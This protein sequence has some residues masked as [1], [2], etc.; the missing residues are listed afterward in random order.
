MTNECKEKIHFNSKPDKEKPN[1]N[2][3]PDKEKPNF[4]NK[5][6]KYDVAIECPICGALSKSLKYRRQSGV[7]F[8]II[9]AHQSTEMYVACPSCVRK[10]ILRTSLLNLLTSHI[11]FPFIFLI[12]EVPQLINSFVGGHC[13]QVRQA[14]DEIELSPE[15]IQ[16]RRKKEKKKKN[17]QALIILAV[18]LLIFGSMIIF[19]RLFLKS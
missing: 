12:I 14:I 19:G 8:L 10:N 18:L 17:R 13:K 16:E 15:E 2:S 9:A 5:H 6:D 1:F 3:K 7:V 4:Q 11:I